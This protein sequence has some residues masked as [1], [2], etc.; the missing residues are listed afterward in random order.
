MSLVLTEKDRLFAQMRGIL[1]HLDAR[2]GW[3]E[4]NRI[5]DGAGA[6]EVFS[7]YA[8]ACGYQAL[9]E[10]FNQRGDDASTE[11]IAYWNA[12]QQQADSLDDD[13]P[14]TLREAL[15]VASGA[16]TRD[17]KSHVR[18]HEDYHIE[19]NAPWAYWPDLG[20]RELWILRD[21]ELVSQVPGSLDRCWF[22]V[23]NFI[24]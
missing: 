12:F 22:P 18:Y 11:F 4:E 17:G 6:L 5:T 10:A 20:S 9:R 16:V 13:S 2:A 23:D 14:L 3:A 24:W 19:L 15:Q 7:G 21:D 1:L 8:D